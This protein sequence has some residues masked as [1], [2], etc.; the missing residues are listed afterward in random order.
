MS[1]AAAAPETRVIDV[2]EAQHRT[3]LNQLGATVHAA[4]FGEIVSVL[5]SSPVHREAKLSDLAKFVAPAVAARQYVVLKVAPAGRPDAALPVGAALWA[6]VSPEVDQRLRAAKDQPVALTPE[7]WRG[8]EH[9]WLV[10]L[11]AVDSVRR[12]LLEDLRDRVAEGRPMALKI[13][14][15]GGDFSVSTVGDVL[16]RL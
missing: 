2:D 8:G 3:V 12:A 10:D 14:D 6:A 7:E 15:A 16:A 11:I 5:M 4:A 1:D 9:L 13:R